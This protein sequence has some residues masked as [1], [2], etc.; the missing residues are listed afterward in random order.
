MGVDL[1]AG[2]EVKNLT[3]NGD[4]ELRLILSLWQTQ[5]G[6]ISQILAELPIEA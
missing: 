3:G 4:A 1:V 2:Q 5:D 6:A